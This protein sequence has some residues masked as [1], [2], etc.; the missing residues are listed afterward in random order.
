MRDLKSVLISAHDDNSALPIFLVGE[1]L[2]AA[3]ALGVASEAPVKIDGLV[4][5]GC[6]DKT[7]RFKTHWILGDLLKYL[8]NPMRDISLEKYQY[9]YA[10]ESKAVIDFT[11][12][13]PLARTNY[14]G[15][16]IIKTLVSVFRTRKKAKAMDQQI[17]LLM[18]NGEKDKI[19]GRVHS[20]HVLNKAKASQKGSMLIAGSGHMLLGRP[21]VFPQTVGCIA[22][23]LDSRVHSV[24]VANDSRRS[25]S[26]T[27]AVMR[28]NPI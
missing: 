2:G 13:D 12:A 27:Q 11:I 18:L 19:A 7:E 21:D 15:P 8:I 6:C 20:Q 10:C 22:Q 14:K 5:T 9:E 23:W 4:L 25:V 26:S 16:E 17:A 28:T 1:S 3:V 24:Q